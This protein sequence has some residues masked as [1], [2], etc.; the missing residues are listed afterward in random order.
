M[1]YRHDGQRQL[2][3]NQSKGI[4]MKTTII[5]GIAA[6]CLVN[7]GLAKGGK[8]GGNGELFDKL[9]A[10]GSGE[11]SKAEWLAGPAKKLPEGKADAVF[12]KVDSDGSGSIDEGEWAEARHGHKGKGKGAGKKKGKGGAAGKGPGKRRG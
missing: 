12:G 7:A 9:D 5:A 3:N 11:L 4:D 2:A 1:L 10:D 8:K 6:L